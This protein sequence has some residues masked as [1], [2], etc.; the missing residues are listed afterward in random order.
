LFE[1]LND[2][3]DNV[4]MVAAKGLVRAR[5]AP[6]Q[7][8]RR[9]IVSVMRA[10][11]DHPLPVARAAALELLGELGEAADRAVV[12]E[13]LKDTDAGVRET[14]QVALKKIDQRIK[15]EAP[16]AP[17]PD[18]VRV[19]G[20]VK[21]P[22]IVSKVEPEYP[23]EARARGASG[24]VVLEA[25]IDVEGEV[26]ATRIVRGVSGLDQAALDAVRQWVYEPTSVAGKRV[27]VIV[28][29]TLSFRP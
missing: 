5:P 18:A 28:M 4:R 6:S 10:L 3:D 14:A 24:I 26:A 27:P 7:E 25:L 22:K 11:V 8:E 9:E 23:E 20:A 15:A 17:P 19:A 21:M 12:T 16:W 13:G 29:L 1:A 2:K